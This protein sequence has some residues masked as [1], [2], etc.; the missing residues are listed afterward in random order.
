MT[1]MIDWPTVVVAFGLFLTGAWLIALSY[2]VVR[3]L[4]WI[5]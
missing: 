3:L 1:H 2:A 5:L 4:E